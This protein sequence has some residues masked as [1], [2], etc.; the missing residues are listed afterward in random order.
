MLYAWVQ[1]YVSA[2]NIAMLESDGK[3][4]DI[5]QIEMTARC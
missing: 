3:H 4:L 5:G 1:G 2:A